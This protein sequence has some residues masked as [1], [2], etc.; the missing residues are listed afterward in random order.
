MKAIVIGGKGMLGGD[1]ARLMRS[2]A[3]FADVAIGDLPEVDITR[4]KSVRAFFE[5]RRPDVV[6]NCAAFTDVDGCESRRD[7]A[8]SVNGESAGRLASMAAS[9]GAHFVHLSSDYVFDGRKGAPYVEDDEPVPLSVYGESKLEGEK[10][11]RQAG[12]RWTIARTAWL[13]G[14]G[15]DNFVERIIRTGRERRESPTLHGYGDG[16]MMGVTDQAGSPTWTRDLAAALIA[17]VKRGTT[18]LFHVANRGV[19]SRYEQVVFILR[20]AGISI[21][22]KAVDGSA[23]PRAARVPVVSELS[24]EKLSR[25]TGHRMRPWREALAEYIRAESPAASG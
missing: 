5:G 4:G 18:G 17:I 25:E 12:G 14:R 22:V 2:D 6:F 24:T 20:C 23:F 16:A 9:L 10:L 19:C 3:G 8:F 7:L 13:Y 21:P 1:L 11:V 15:G